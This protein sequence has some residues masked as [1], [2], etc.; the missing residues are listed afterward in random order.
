[1]ASDRTC[2]CQQVKGITGIITISLFPL[3]MTTELPFILAISLA[4]GQ[5][6][7]LCLAVSMAYAC[8]HANHGDIRLQSGSGELCP[9]CK[10]PKLMDSHHCTEC[11]Q[12]IVGYRHHSYWLNSCI[13]SANAAAYILCLAGL[14][15]TAV[16]QTTALLT[17]L[18]LMQGDFQLTV[19]LNEKYSL[20]DEG[21]L[22][23]LGLFFGIF[24]CASLMISSIIGCF[25]H[26]IH[27]FTRYKRRKMIFSHI[28]PS[29]YPEKRI[30]ESFDSINVMN[31][32]RESAVS[33]TDRHIA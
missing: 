18:V 13:G 7:G 27:S 24:V 32:E 6:A 3:L 29:T 10:Q 23:R 15:C 19:K 31:R 17:L 22:F 9:Q 16:C 30:E 5:L 20:A 14:S 12:C 8:Y 26:L 28:Q 1:M 4:S 2:T 21:F 25:Y 33:F 11:D